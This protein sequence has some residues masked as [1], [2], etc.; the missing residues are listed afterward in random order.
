MPLDTPLPAQAP[1]ISVVTPCFNEAGN[2]REMYEAIK[3]VFAGLPQYRYEHIFI[4]NASKDSTVSILRSIATD[5]RNVKVIVNARNFGHV[6]SGYH[7]ILQA[8]GDAVIAIACDFQ[9]PPELI[10]DFLRRWSEGARVVLGIKESS[11]ESGVFYRLR[12][13]YYRLLARIADI[14]LVRQSTGFGCFDQSVIEALRHIDDPYPYFRGLLA[15]IGHEPS[16][17]PFRQPERKRGLSSQ[18]FYTLYDLAFLG[19]VNHSKVPLRMATMAG[20]GLAL[21]SLLVAF[22]YLGYKLLFWNQFSVGIAPI[23][24]GFFFLTSVQLFFIGIVGEYIGSIYT[25]VR[26]HPHVFEKERINY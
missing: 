26:H 7:A 6:R 14:E 21:L 3:D 8:R 15:E 20:F 13:S 22:G 16:L 17:V 10:P 2:V 24:I 19:I 4:D 11:D 25:Q 18:N 12:D 1:L 5:D 9:D 23:L